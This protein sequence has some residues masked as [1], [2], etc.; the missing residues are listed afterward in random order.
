MKQRR[1]WTKKRSSEERKAK[2]GETKRTGKG[3]SPRKHIAQMQGKKE[4]E[5]ETNTHLRKKSF[6][7]E[8]LKEVYHTFSNYNFPMVRSFLGLLIAWVS[9][10]GVLE[11][12][13][14]VRS[15]EI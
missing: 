6:W 11:L 15:G 10:L 13:G 7:Q 4:M 14:L 5:Q 9:V 12:S 2:E 3:N 1:T 8:G